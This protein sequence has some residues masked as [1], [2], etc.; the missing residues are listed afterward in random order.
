MHRSARTVLAIL[1][2]SFTHATGFSQSDI[3]RVQSLSQLRADTT[4]ARVRAEYFDLPGDPLGQRGTANVLIFDP[5]VPAAV[6]YGDL[7]GLPKT[8]A[9]QLFSEAV[10][11]ANAI[12][13]GRATASRAYL[14]LHDTY[15]FTDFTFTVGEW[16]R[17]A[18]TPHRTIVFSRLGGAARVGD[19]DYSS[20]APFAIPINVSMIV[21]GTEIKNASSY[22]AIP[23]PITIRGA[24]VDFSADSPGR[25]LGIGS[26][27]EFLKE[28]RNAAK[29]CK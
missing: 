16:I 12:I 21:F 23:A 27:E 10:C 22:H 20:G 15:L 2:A 19:I 24:E 17:P 18:N 29:A 9:A 6:L 8:S 5:P 14:N 13:V 25:T 3:S 11:Q 1:I 4:E 7:F 28:L 26:T